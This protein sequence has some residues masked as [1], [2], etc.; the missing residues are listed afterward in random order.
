[1]RKNHKTKV[2]DKNLHRGK[3]N[4]GAIHLKKALH[5]PYKEE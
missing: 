2:N 3:N 4:T 5:L 1:M